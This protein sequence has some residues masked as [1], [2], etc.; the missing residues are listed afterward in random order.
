MKNFMDYLYKDVYQKKNLYLIKTT[1]SLPS[2]IDMSNYHSVVTGTSNRNFSDNI[3]AISL[4]ASQTV[5]TSTEFNISTAIT[6]LNEIQYL[7][8]GGYMHDSNNWYIGTRGQWFISNV[9]YGRLQTPTV[10]LRQ[11]NL[12]VFAN[13]SYLDSLATASKTHPGISSKGVI[14]VKANTNAGVIVFQ[15][16]TDTN[17]L[18]YDIQ[19]GKAVFY[20]RASTDTTT[21]TETRSMDLKNGIFK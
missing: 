6:N 21:W 18:V 2:A 19:N 15:N 1:T 12:G 7:S 20:E 17:S 11:E 5:T 13:G 4:P 14:F 10:S 16:M 9:V 3:S 8:L